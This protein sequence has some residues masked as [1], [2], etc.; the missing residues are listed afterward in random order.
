MES[1]QKPKGNSWVQSYAQSSRYVGAGIQ[2]AVSTFLCLLGGTWLDRQWGTSP[3]LLFLGTFLG[4]GAGF[5]NFYKILTSTQSKP[6]KGGDP[7]GKA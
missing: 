4:A 7:C 1:G 3:L 6:K 2:L 5:Y